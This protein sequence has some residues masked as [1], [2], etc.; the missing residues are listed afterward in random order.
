M[1]RIAKLMQAS[2]E[3]IRGG[4]MKLVGS[5]VSFDEYKAHRG[6]LTLGGTRTSLQLK[7]RWSMIYVFH[8]LDRDGVRELR[9]S[10][11]VPPTGSIWPWSPTGSPSRVP[12]L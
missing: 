6:F 7:V 2:L 12:C 3:D 5:G 10:R 8:L 11:F 1:M 9:G 4:E